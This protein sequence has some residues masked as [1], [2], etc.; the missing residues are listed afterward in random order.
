M[1]FG[2]FYYNVFLKVVWKGSKKEIIIVSDDV[3]SGEKENL[4]SK[5]GIV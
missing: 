3:K 2:V 5:D 4:I 1:V